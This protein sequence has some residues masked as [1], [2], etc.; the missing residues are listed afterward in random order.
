MCLELWSQSDLYQKPKE[1]LLNDFKSEVDPRG[2]TLTMHLC[3]VPETSKGP[4]YRD[5]KKLPE[6]QPKGAVQH[7]HMGQ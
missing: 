7:S 3:Q 1:W 2:K 5:H 4:A 6:R